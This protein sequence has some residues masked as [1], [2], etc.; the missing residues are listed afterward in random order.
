[1]EE[2]NMKMFNM[3]SE[4]RLA[5]VSYN[6]LPISI[7]ATVNFSVEDEVVIARV[8]ERAIVLEVTRKMVS[9]PRSMY[10]LSVTATVRRTLNDNVEGISLKELDMIDFVNKNKNELTN[11]AF[12]NVSY[13]IASIIGAFGGTPLL[14][15]PAPV[16]T[17]KVYKK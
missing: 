9:N 3:R 14:T 6:L 7:G 11:V 15:P 12:M 16:A 10:D 8:E 17:V 2:L 1:M 5:N 4:A 13:I